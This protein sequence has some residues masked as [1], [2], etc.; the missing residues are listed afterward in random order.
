M[1][2]YNENFYFLCYFKFQSHRNLNFRARRECR[3]Y[4]KPFLMKKGGFAEGH[5]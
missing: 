4:P 1:S 2:E 5:R 3:D